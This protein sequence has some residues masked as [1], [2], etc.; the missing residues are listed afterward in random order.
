[1]ESINIT[2]CKAGFS[3]IDIKTTIFEFRKIKFED[4]LNNVFFSEDS[5][6]NLTNITILNHNCFENLQGCTASIYN[7]VIT[8]QFLEIDTLASYIEEGTLYFWKAEGEISNVIFN[9]INNF[10]QIGSCISGYESKLDVKNSLFSKYDGNCIYGYDSI[11]SIDRCQFD[12]N[13][14]TINGFIGEYGAIF[15][16]NT[17]ISILSSKFIGNLLSLNGAGIYL[18]DSFTFRSP[19]KT[20]SN[21]TFIRNSVQNQGGGLFLKNQNIEI[22]NCTFLENEAENGGAIYLFNEGKN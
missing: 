13:T 10:K 1:M 11:F 19:I 5:T 3:L 12:T 14:N 9:N 16:V 22:N 2:N 4:N 21:T 15:S 17:Q 20:I 6:L 8:I 18:S 7:S